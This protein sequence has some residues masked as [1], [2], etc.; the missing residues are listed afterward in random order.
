MGRS[1][2][3]TGAVVGFALSAAIAACNVATDQRDLAV[4]LFA[5]AAVTVAA[6]MVY[7]FVKDEA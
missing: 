7:A 1:D 5:C 3:S 6:A 2:F 4:R